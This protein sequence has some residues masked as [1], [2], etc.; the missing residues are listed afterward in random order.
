MRKPR[1][2]FYVNPPWLAQSILFVLACLVILGLLLAHNYFLKLEA[3][4]FAITSGRSEADR[5]FSR[6][7]LWSY[8]VKQYKFGPDDSGTVPTDG[9]S[10]PSGKSDGKLEIR[11]YLVSKEFEWGHLE[12]QQAYVDAYNERIHLLISHP[13]WFDKSGHRIP[14]T[15]LKPQTNTDSQSPDK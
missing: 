10:E 5:N 13:E 8:E 2:S 7:Y 15:G 12:I 1:V 9:T 14:P 4:R 6:G 3:K 11:Y